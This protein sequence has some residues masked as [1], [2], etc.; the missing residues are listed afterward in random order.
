TTR[1][2]VQ[3]SLRRAGFDFTGD[4]ADLRHRRVAAYPGAVLHRAGCADRAHQRGV[5]DGID[6]HVLYSDNISGF[7]RGY[8]R[9]TRQD[10]H[11]RWYEYERAPAGA[12]ARRRFL[13]CI[14]RGHCLRHYSRRGCWLDDQRFDFFRARLL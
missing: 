14:H 12:I 11:Q 7:W 1:L 3:T 13:L 5:G 4:G 10:R 2:T 6:W 9:W 8:D